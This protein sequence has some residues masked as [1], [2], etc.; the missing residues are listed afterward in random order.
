MD[1]ALLTVTECAAALGVSRSLAYEL[2][3]KGQLRSIRIGRA[4]RIPARAISEFV[5]AKELEAQET[6]GA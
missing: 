3:N 1:K 4:R 6:P 2:L 5:A